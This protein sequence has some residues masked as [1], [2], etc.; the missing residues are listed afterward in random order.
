MSFQSDLTGVLK[1]EIGPSAALFY[2]K[3]MLQLRKDALSITS[4]DIE[5]IADFAYE[6]IRSMIDEKTAFRVRHRIIEIQPNAKELK[7]PFSSPPSTKLPGGLS[8]AGTVKDPG[9]PEPPV[10]VMEDNTLSEPDITSIF[11]KISPPVQEKN[12]KAPVPVPPAQTAAPVHM[13]P[14]KSAPS[15]IPPR[16]MAG[17]P[18]AGK[19]PLPEERELSP[20]GRRIAPETP[21]EIVHDSPEDTVSSPEDT[22]P[23]DHPGTKP[24]TLAD[25]IDELLSVLKTEG[26]TPDLWTE[27]ADLYTRT[28]KFRDATGAYEKV[29]G[30][31]VETPVIWNCLGDSY[32]KSGQ[33]EDSDLAYARSL[34]LEPNDPA[35][36]LKRARVLASRNRYDDALACCDHSLTKDESSAVAWHYKAFVLKKVGRNEDALEIY[37][38]LRHLDPKDENAVRQETAIR[39]LLKN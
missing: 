36:W 23:V 9:P 17:P 28:G 37:T 22:G 21:G 11:S 3:C 6:E 20:D 1:A 12:S 18:P 13:Y 10:H 34:E 4:S 7:R 25:R 24:A 2:K 39:K 31:G 15:T 32:K 30:L 16:Y 8:A 19:T 38:Y 35:V 33:Y 5:E 29:V 14:V 27:L 26:E